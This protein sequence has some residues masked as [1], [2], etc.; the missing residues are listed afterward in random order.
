MHSPAVFLLFANER[1]TYSMAIVVALTILSW[2]LFPVLHISLTPLTSLSYCH[3]FLGF[4]EGGFVVRFTFEQHALRSRYSW[5]YEH[6]PFCHHTLKASP[7]DQP[8]SLTVPLLHQHQGAY[9]QAQPWKVK[10]APCPPWVWLLPLLGGTRAE[11]PIVGGG[12]PSAEG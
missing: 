9:L 6:S 2:F 4:L 10:P 11:V 7:P 3:C 12:G 5:W 8:R 1:F